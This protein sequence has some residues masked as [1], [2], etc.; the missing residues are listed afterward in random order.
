MRPF[1]R[2]TEPYCRFKDDR[3]RLR[4]LISRDIRIVL[5][6]IALVASGPLQS[7]GKRLG[8]VLFAAV[9]R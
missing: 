7:A 2:D 3:S 4:A 1:Q 5:V 8:D 6:A 9:S